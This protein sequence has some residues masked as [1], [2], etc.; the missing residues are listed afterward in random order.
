[1]AAIIGWMDTDDPIAGYGAGAILYA[2]AEDLTETAGDLSPNPEYASHGGK[3]PRRRR[4]RTLEHPALDLYGGH[5]SLLV[6]TALIRA[7][8]YTG[9]RLPE[10]SRALDIAELCRHLAYADN[11]HIV[12]IALNNANRVHAINETG[13]GPA[14]T[15]TSNA[16][17]ILKVA[18]LTG[19]PAFA[20][21]HNHPSGDPTPSLDDINFTMAAANAAECVGLIMLDH[22]IV[23]L[24]GW[25]TLSDLARGRGAHMFKDLDDDPTSA[26]HMGWRRRP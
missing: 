23:A 9:K 20:V 1:M 13:V 16:M 8:N 26:I 4:R 10:I 2:P 17:Q 6:R 5:E 22:I 7:D 15:V 3:A 19:S 14:N 12:I 21:V 25:T 11:E 18:F 24:D